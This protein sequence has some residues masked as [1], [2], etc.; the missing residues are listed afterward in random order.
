MGPDRQTSTEESSGPSS[1]ESTEAQ[2]EGAPKEADEGSSGEEESPT[3]DYLRNVGDSVAAMLDP[4]G[5]L[6]ILVHRFS[7]FTTVHL[8]G[9]LS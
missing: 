8:N 9:I 6:E 3:E 5:E 1:K 4:L 7:P 2:K